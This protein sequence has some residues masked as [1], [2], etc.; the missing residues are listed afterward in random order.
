MFI[1]PLGE[2]LVGVLVVYIEKEDLHIDE[3]YLPYD[4]EWE[5]R[6]ENR[7]SEL[8]AYRADPQSLPPRLPMTVKGGKKVKNWQCGG[9]WGSCP[10]LD[11]C[12]KEDGSGVAPSD[13][14]I[15]IEEW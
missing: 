4:V 8:E 14:P 7:L 15:V 3:H 10:F 9:A 6:V 5:S 11:K 12:W 2:K 1:P 13:D